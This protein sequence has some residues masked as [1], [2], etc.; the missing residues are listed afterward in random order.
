MPFVDRPDARLYYEVHGTGTP[1][2]LIMGVGGNLRWWGSGFVRK[3][4]ARHTV[5]AFDNRGAGESEAHPTEPWTIEEMADDAHAVL[6][7]AGFSRAHVLGYSMGG[8]IAQELA[9]RH[10]EAVD[11]LVLGAT[12]CGGP[13]MIQAEDVKREMRSRPTD[14]A[15]RAE[16]YMRLFFP[17]EFRAKNEAY[18]RGAFR[19]LLRADMPEAV[20][21]AQLDAVERWQGSWDRLSN[22]TSRTLVMHGLSDRVLPY[23]NGERLAYRMPGARL[24]LYAGCGHG[25]AMQAGA[26]V[27]RDVLMFLGGEAAKEDR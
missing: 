23:A 15:A 16:W 25:F 1:L 24:K 2:L 20:Y 19:L 26:A 4:A 21:Q 10:P 6:Q 14:L 17:E 8:M 22:V 3:L 9:L 5:I 13:Q 18:L 12:S 7:D 27:L 11:A